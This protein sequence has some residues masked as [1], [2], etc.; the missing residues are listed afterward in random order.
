MLST[1]ARDTPIY[2]FFNWCEAHAAS[3]EGKWVFLFCTRNNNDLD[4]VQFVVN[5]LGSTA[6]AGFVF[7][8]LP[9]LCHL[10]HIPLSQL[11]S[12]LLEGQLSTPQ[13]ALCII[14]QASVII[15]TT[16]ILC[17]AQWTIFFSCKTQAK[18]ELHRIE[19]KVDILRG[20]KSHDVSIRDNWRC[21]SVADLQHDPVVISSLI[22]PHS[23]YQSNKPNEIPW[24]QRIWD[25][26]PLKYTVR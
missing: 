1:H 25:S 17:K 10:K 16:M 19:E 2:L 13:S 20:S 18:Q 23:L 14:A 22:L 15:I 3:D 11:P 9:V 5:T 24:C 7:L 21:V 4:V 6:Q 12:Y 8:L 26:Q